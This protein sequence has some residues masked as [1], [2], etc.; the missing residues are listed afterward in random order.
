MLADALV[1]SRSFAPGTRVLDVGTGAGA[2]GLALALMRPDLVVTLCEPLAKRTSFLRTVLGTVGRSDVRIE[3][4]FAR[5]ALYR[6]AWAL[7]TDDEMLHHDAAVAK[8]L[9]SDLGVNAAA[10]SLQLHGAIGY[11]W[12]HDL[13]LLMKRTWAVAASHG[14]AATQRARAWG[15]G[16]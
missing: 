5:P 8:A 11:T 13:Q 4:E 14:D 9:A 12:E 6:A 1:M 7:A 16:F 3:L 2:P 15:L 10:T